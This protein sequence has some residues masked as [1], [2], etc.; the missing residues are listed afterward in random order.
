MKK[1][2][3]TL[4]NKTRDV[5]AILQWWS[6]ALQTPALATLARMEARVL[7]SVASM[8][9][10]ALHLGVVTTARQVSAVTNLLAD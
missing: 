8:C 1:N 7:F 4:C 9:V 2:I 6:V 10:S 3:I 5:C